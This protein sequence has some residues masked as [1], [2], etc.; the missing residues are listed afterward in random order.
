MAKG[1]KAGKSDTRQVGGGKAKADAKDDVTDDNAKKRVPF[2]A[3]KKPADGWTEAVPEG[4]DFDKHLIMK[5]DE[6]ATQVPFMRHR[7]ASLT[8]RSTALAAEAKSLEDKA[9]RYEALGDE[10]TRSQVKRA[11]RIA[12]QLEGLIGNLKDAGVDIESILLAVKEKAD[13]AKAEAAETEA[14]E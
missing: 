3:K 9:T 5:K 8:H 6:F 2:S 7:A 14:A 12:G 4:F 13:K 11:E 1:K 10:K